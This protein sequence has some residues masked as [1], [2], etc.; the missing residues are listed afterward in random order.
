MEQEVGDD[1]AGEWLRTFRDLPGDGWT[2]V[3]H[4]YS[5]IEGLYMHRYLLRPV[6]SKAKKV[7][8]IYLYIYTMEIVLLILLLNN[9]QFSPIT[10][11]YCKAGIPWSYGTKKSPEQV[12]AVIDKI[13]KSYEAGN[14]TKEEYTKLMAN[15]G[16]VANDIADHDGFSR[17]YGEPPITLSESAWDSWLVSHQGQ[18]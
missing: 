4:D 12:S 11:G 10:L 15:A 14:I 6:S 5:Q 2:A 13:K 8:S 1:K 16:K 18:Y 3:L 17:L 9:E 7:S